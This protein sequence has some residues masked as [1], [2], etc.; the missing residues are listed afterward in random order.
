MGR[1]V[2]RALGK[3]MGRSGM[4]ADKEALA[5]VREAKKY[6]LEVERSGNYFVFADPLRVMES[7]AVPDSGLGPRLSSYRESLRTLG[8]TVRARSRKAEAEAAPKPVVAEPGS[9]QMP[10]SSSEWSI[11]ELM[12]RLKAAGGDVRVVGGVLSVTGR[13]L[14]GLANLVL[15]REAEV[16]AF[17]ARVR[18]VAPELAVEAQL[19]EAAPKKDEGQGAPVVQ[20]AAKPARRQQAADPDAVDVAVVAVEQVLERRLDAATRET[21][22]ILRKSLA[23]TLRKAE[24]EVKEANERAAIAETLLKEVE[25]KLAKVTGERDDLRDFFEKWNRLRSPVD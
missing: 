1:S 3:A 2:G 20:K 19:P 22:D 25:E 4:K 10:G 15:A 16:M 7:V 12:S 11:D 23:L 18:P 8:G 9:E 13:D 14:G 17:L 6:G 21:M 24:E 5:L